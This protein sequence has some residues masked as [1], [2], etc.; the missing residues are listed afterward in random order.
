MIVTL[1]LF[2]NVG[3]FGE[4]YTVL[5]RGNRK[6]RYAGKDTLHEEIFKKFYSKSEADEPNE[7]EICDNL[8]CDTAHCKPTRLTTH[9]Q[10]TYLQKITNM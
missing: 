4:K 10:N 5:D 3:L 2:F 7:C 6:V 1:K 8:D 9:R